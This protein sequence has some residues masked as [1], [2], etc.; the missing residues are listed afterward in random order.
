[1][2]MFVI[3]VSRVVMMVMVRAFASEWVSRNF[4]YWFFRNYDFRK[5]EMACY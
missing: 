3:R 4:L 5:Y 1:M 2:M